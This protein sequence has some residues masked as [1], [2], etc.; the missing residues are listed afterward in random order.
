MEKGNKIKIFLAIAYTVILTLF[1]WT[2]FSKFSLNDLTSY[3]FIKNNRDY[4]IEIKEKNLFIV[5][6]LFFIFT[7]IWVF[8]LGFGTPIFLIGGFIFGK[9]LG[10]F[11][12]VLGLTSGATLLY[13]F[14]NY[15]LKDFIKEK[16]SKR[17]I[18]LNEKFKKNEFIYFLFYRFLGGIPFAIS[19]VIPTLFNIK[20]KFFFLGSILGMT[21]QLFIGTTLGS[22]LE[23]IINENQVAPSFLEILLYPDVIYPIIGLI[24]LLI[25]TLIIR[26]I[27]YKK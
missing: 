20:I 6:I 12:V 17:F 13:I 19:N 1:L 7:V 21:P 5:S 4:L 26:N 3:D 14:A 22:G 27:F 9:W 16:F 10:T 25:I 24:V 11:L 15:F 2:F 18:S 23:K 8:M